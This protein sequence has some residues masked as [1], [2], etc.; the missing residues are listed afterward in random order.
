M[1]AMSEDL[2]CFYEALASRPTLHTQRLTLRMPEE[3]DIP[4][5]IAIVGDWEVASRLARIPHPYTEEHA[6]F[7]LDEIVPAELAWSITD[8]A[9]GEM[10]G[11][12]G[13]APYAQEAGTI[14]LGYYLGRDHWGRGIATEASAVVM[15]YGAGLVGQHRLRSG[16]FADNPASGR[17]LQKLG[18]KQVST[19][20][21]HCLT[22]G[23][24]KP[25]VEM[26][27]QA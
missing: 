13:L 10:V 26:A 25:S 20:K 4:A 21:R 5:L 22:T 1:L 9:T 2:K 27:Y 3:R 7:F 18:Y 12:V 24:L 14:E 17:V 6:R 15:A 19:S 11:V 16:Y 8:R 23:E